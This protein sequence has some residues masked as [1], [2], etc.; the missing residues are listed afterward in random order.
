[1]LGLPQNTH[2]YLIQP[3]A[4]DY[5]VK[6]VFAK[7][8]LQFCD[9]LQKSPKVAV[10]DT[11]EKV[12]ANVKTTTGKNLVELGLLLN[13]PIGNLSPHDAASIEFARVADE[14]KF[15]INFIKELIDVK[16]GD[17]E[18]AGFLDD[19]LEE[20]V[21]Y[22]CTSEV[23]SGCAGWLYLVV[24]QQPPY[25]VVFPPGVPGFSPQSIFVYCM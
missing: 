18:V 1:M 17:L 7:R 14:E 23:P 13:K 5:H 9:K 12:K 24:G 20:I 11:F 8:F 25:F 6:Q 15:R 4:N 19:E 10:R 21:E 22:L 3:L 16:H 2:R